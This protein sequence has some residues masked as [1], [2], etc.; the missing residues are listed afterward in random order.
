MDWDWNLTLQFQSSGWDATDGQKWAF[1]NGDWMLSAY[2]YPRCYVESSTWVMTGLSLFI[3]EETN[4]FRDKVKP[5]LLRDSLK[6]TFFQH[7]GWGWHSNS[8][9]MDP[10]AP[11]TQLH[12]E[13]LW[14]FWRTR[15]ESGGPMEGDDHSY[16]TVLLVASQAINTYF[17]INWIKWVKPQKQRLW[18][19]IKI[20]RKLNWT[21]NWTCGLGKQLF[22]NKNNCIIRHRSL[23]N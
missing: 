15:W 21:E 18:L 11:P 8:D 23:V 16:F 3:N 13:T 9:L 10:R 6:E 2:Q 19:D 17:K 22:K 12:T 7:Q 20:N 14:Y 4:T 5:R 1:S